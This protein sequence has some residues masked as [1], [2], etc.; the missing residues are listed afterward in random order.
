MKNVKSK[1]KESNEDIKDKKEGRK[2]Q[3]KQ[4]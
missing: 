4:N 2:Q 3:Q 1:T